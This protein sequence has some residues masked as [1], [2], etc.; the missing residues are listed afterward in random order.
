MR[1]YRSLFPNSFTM[2]NMLC[3]FLSVL[4]SLE[5]NATTAAWLIVLGAFLDSL[6]G[7]IARMSKVSSRFGIELDSFSDFLTFGVA[8]GVLLHAFKL[9]TV[10]R[11]SWMIS[12]VYV[13]CSGYRLARYNLLAT[14]EE[15]KKF[16]GLPVPVAS[17]LLVSYVIFSYKV[18]GDIE[19]GEFLISMIA[20]VSVLM[21]SGV[22]Y[23]TFPENLLT[24][25]NK[26][27]FLLLFVFFI[28]LIIKPRLVMF[29]AVLVYVLGCFI[30]ELVNMLKEEQH[31]RKINNKD[32]SKPGE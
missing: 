12:G 4:S 20:V 10:G 17:M 7:K 23:E 25:E 18:W 16:L 29:P 2:G 26:L 14:L 27:K 5:G 9:N 30:R 3:G 21:V 6:D 15:K 28:G 1:N 22:T 24:F 31:K 8:T 11:W 19:Y 13:M 32:R